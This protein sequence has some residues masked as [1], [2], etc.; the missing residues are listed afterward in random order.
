MQLNSIQ[1][2]RSPRILL[3]LDRDHLTPLSGVRLQWPNRSESAVFDLNFAGLA[4]STQVQSLVNTVTIDKLKIGHVFDL[5]LK[6]QGLSE[7]LP[8]KLKVI[9]QTAQVI[10]FAFDTISAQGRLAIEQTCKDALIG[11]HLRE[12]SSSHLHPHLQADSWWHGPFDTNLFLWRE[13]G[14]ELSKVVIEYDNLIW[15]YQPGKVSLVRS[16]AS[17][18]EAHGYLPPQFETLLQKMAMGHDWMARLRRVLEAVPEL[19]EDVLELLRE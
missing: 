2:K 7:P 5:A 3:A 16:M 1:I 17:H 13:D 10:G 19:P 9:S 6:I 12:E 14:R 4:A 18:P 8:V 15:I 11:Q